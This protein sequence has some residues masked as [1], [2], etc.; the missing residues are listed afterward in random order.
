MSSPAITG[1][2]AARSGARA[3][4]LV[5]LLAFLITT[6]TPAFANVPPPATG[7]CAA[8]RLPHASP[9]TTAD[10]DD[11]SADA[12]E[13][14]QAFAFPGGDRGVHRDAP[15]HGGGHRACIVSDCHHR[16]RLAVP[17]QHQVVRDALA[18]VTAPGAQGRAPVSAHH[19]PGVQLP[20]NVVLR[21]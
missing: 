2:H 5:A 9:P 15:H 16:S 3:A 20:Q 13:I 21:C 19:V 1:R 18:R 12:C 4:L 10:D 7:G 8:L 6:F 14:P 17:G 11:D